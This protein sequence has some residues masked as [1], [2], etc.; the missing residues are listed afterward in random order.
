MLM[1]ALPGVSAA[2]DEGWLVDFEAAKQQAAKE[3]KSILMEFTGSDWCPPC[4]AFKK[5]V[6]DTDVFKTRAP[7]KFVLLKLDNPNDKSKQT[8][9]EIAQYR[10][11]AEDY[12]VSGVPT[13]IL[14]DDAGRPFAKNVGFGG[15]E[16][17]AYV[18]N[19]EGQLANRT[20]RDELLAQAGKAQGADRAKLLDQAIAVVDAELAV[21]RYAA[22]VAEISKLDGE[23]KAGL[24]AKYEGV[25]KAAEVRAAMAG[26]RRLGPTPEALAKVEEI[27]ATLKPEG[28]ALQDLLIGKGLITAQ[29]GDKVAA[30]AILQ[31][32]LEAAPT[33]RMARSLSNFLA[34][35]FKDVEDSKSPPA[36]AEKGTANP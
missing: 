14:A 32:A 27:L 31:Q 5:K 28:E 29:L 26:I 20:K 35:Q 25:A 34:Q 3:G 13:I 16:P 12:R 17:G 10:K 23:N 19:L 1:I 6:L 30:K 11:L 15:Q 9:A 18:D 22:E 36:K 8:P 4:I 2:A 21:S 33:S 24:K 7:E